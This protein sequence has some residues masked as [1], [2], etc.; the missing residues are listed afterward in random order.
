MLVAILGLIP[1]PAPFAAVSAAGTCALPHVLPPVFPSRLPRRSEAVVADSAAVLPAGHLAPY[2][3]SGGFFH[4]SVRPFVPDFPR[5]PCAHC[6]LHLVYHGSVSDSLLDHCAHPCCCERCLCVG[7]GDR[8]GDRVWCEPAVG[9][10]VHE[11]RYVYLLPHCAYR[12]E[13]CAARAACILTSVFCSPCS[14][15]ESQGAE[16][17]AHDQESALVG[18]CGC[19]CFSKDH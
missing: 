12:F 13:Y 3:P 15:Y 1:D 6:D 9:W 11:H 18:V 5:V 10:D 7:F 2:V 14:L 19:G 16:A 8:I 4:R 17:V